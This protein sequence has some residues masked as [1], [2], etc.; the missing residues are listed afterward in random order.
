MGV[1]EIAVQPPG[2][3]K[4]PVPQLHPPIR[5]EHRDRLKQAVKGRGAGAQQRVAHRGNPQG[6]GAVLD[7]QQQAAIGHRLRH[8]TQMRAIGQRPGFLLRL[9]R[10]EPLRA[11]TAPSGVI[12]HFRHAACI[13]RGVQQAL[14]HRWPLARG[15]VQRRIGQGEMAL[16]RLV[17]EHQ[18]PLRIKLR[19]ARRQLVQHRSLRLA[20]GAER[21]RQF[22]HILDVDGITRD[23]LWPQ[24]QVRHAHHAPSAGALR[25]GNRG[26]DH[27]VGW[28][29]LGGGGQRDV[30]GAEP[31]NA[32]DQFCAGCNHFIAAGAAHR[33]HIGAVDQ[34][35]GAIRPAEPH[36]HGGG[37]DQ[38]HQSSEIA[39]R[40][41]GLAAQFLQLA[42]AVAGVEHPDQRRAAR[43]NLRISQ[44]P[45]QGQRTPRTQRN[46]RHTERRP[47]PLGA[48]HRLGEF[49]Q[50]RSGQAVFARNTGQFGK[51]L[52][53]RLQP[54]PLGQ[55]RRRLNLAIGADQ[56][57][58]RGRFVDHPRQSPP[59]AQSGLCAP[60]PHPR[61][62]DRPAS[63]E[64]PSGE[65]QPDQG[66]G[67]RR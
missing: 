63:A 21:A 17:G 58:Q 52:R 32:L 9:G 15:G 46:S 8:Q 6:F 10:G 59:L 3:G 61:P 30:A 57:R 54:Q 39:A 36:W 51:E 2:R 35:Q 4:T 26:A 28:R 29:A 38:A 42:L 65:Q 45:A 13:A 40:A 25:V 66:Q 56:H 11:F 24:R 55:T 12:A 41:L 60:L 1:E 53:Y 34:P 14:E 27:A 7:D 33:A 44:M 49:R 48:A 50:L 22:L 37:L 19:H 43:R 47:S 64:R 62:E 18:L 16:E 20:E 23:A 31:I 67:N 5:R